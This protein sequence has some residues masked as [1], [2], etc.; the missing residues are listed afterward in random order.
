MPEQLQAT[1][2]LLTE[3]RDLREA[4]EVSEGKLF[5]IK[6][7]MG[8][9][10]VVVLTVIIFGWQAW[11]ASNEAETASDKAAKAVTTT[12]NNANETR[13]NQRILWDFVINISDDGGPKEQVALAKIQTWIHDLFAERDCSNPTRKYNV[14]EPPD[15]LKLINSEAK[16]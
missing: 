8:F 10:A 9:M 2:D 7:I 4:I 14:P 11:E 1:K 12:C 3:V 6:V 15:I 16:K 5:T 13:K